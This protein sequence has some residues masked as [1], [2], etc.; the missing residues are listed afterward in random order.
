[1]PPTIR[2]I[3]TG[4]VTTIPRQYLYHH[5]VIPYRSVPEGR[6][7]M[8]VITFLID[9]GGGLILV[10]TGMAPTERASKYHHPQSRQPEGLAIAERLASLGLRCS[11]VDMVILTHLHWDHCFYL[12]LFERATILV[13]ERERLFAYDPIPMYYKS[14][15]HPSIGVVRPFEGARLTD[16]TKDQ[17]AAPGVTV[18]ETPGHSP[19]HVS[20]EVE[21]AFGP[22]VIAGDA[23][24]TPHNL[25]PV[26]ELGYDV[27][28]P[29]R[30]CDAIQTWSSLRRIKERAPGLDRV[31]CSHDPK[32]LEPGEPRPGLLPALP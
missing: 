4:F 23:A 29:G 10:D 31:L 32:L 19:G 25:L 20:V 21:T 17:A 11:D 30:F 14:Y 9:T 13:H 1:M 22:Y 28:P 8:P 16:V 15:E 26:E 7:E 18:L 6:I 5:S 3:N 27:C 24:F 12:G 2:P